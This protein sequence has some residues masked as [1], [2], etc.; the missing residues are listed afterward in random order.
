MT[1][2][3]KVKASISVLSVSSQQHFEAE[4]TN[5]SAKSD[6]VQTTWTRNQQIM[7]SG[8]IPA[9]NPFTMSRRSLMNFRRKTCNNQGG[10]YRSVPTTCKNQRLDDTHKP[11]QPAEPQKRCTKEI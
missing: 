2:N 1:E 3:S 7:M 10:C 11:Y 8:L 6:L 5:S 9:I 4:I